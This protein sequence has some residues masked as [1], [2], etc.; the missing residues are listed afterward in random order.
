M[1]TF[2]EKTFGSHADLGL[3][4]AEERQTYLD[5]WSAPGALTAMFNWY[6]ASEIVVPA[7]GEEAEAP[8]WTAA[9]FPKLAMP[10][11]VIWG[12]KDKA[13]LP[14]QIDGLP[15]LID[16]FRLAATPDAGHFI[17]WEYPEFVVSAI[18]DFMAETA[19]L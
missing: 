10:T 7:P 9:P 14:V 17:P 3:I 2:Y 16:D 18:R 12:L 13:L 11:L 15:E 19:R 4:A 5:Q 1:E 6:R 8:A